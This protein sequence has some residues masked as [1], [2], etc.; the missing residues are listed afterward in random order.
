VLGSSLAGER[1]RAIAT[2]QVM[3]EATAVSN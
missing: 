1:L 2:I 3:G